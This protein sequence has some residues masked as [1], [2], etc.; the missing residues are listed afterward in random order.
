MVAKL[1]IKEKCI[2]VFGVQTT[3]GSIEAKAIGLL[4]P[5]LNVG[6]GGGGGGGCKLALKLNILNH[7][8][9]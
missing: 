9:K 7:P 3:C 6:L 4:T 5:P 1:Y 8:R 2:G